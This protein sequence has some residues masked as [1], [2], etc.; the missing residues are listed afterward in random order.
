MKYASILLFTFLFPAVASAQEGIALKK[1]RSCIS[2]SHIYRNAAHYRNDGERPET[3]YKFIQ[4]A[5][6]SEA[7]EFGIKESDIKKIINKVYFDPQ[8]QFAG[9]EALETQMYQ[10]CMGKYKPIEPLK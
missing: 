3:T 10:I 1:Q 9:G 2:I 5:F 4:Q 8:F 7:H 6:N